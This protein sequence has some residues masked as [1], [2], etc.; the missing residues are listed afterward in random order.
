[1]SPFCG[2]LVL[3]WRL[4]RAT[5]IETGLF[6][7]QADYLSGFRRG[8]QVNPGKTTTTMPTAKTRP[9]PPITRA[10]TNDGWIPNDPLPFVLYRD[11]VDLTGSPDPER[12]IGEIPTAGRN[13]LCRDS[14]AEH[15]K[16]LVSIRTVPRPEI[17]P[18]FGPQGPLIM[19]WRL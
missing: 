7:I 14:K 19:L 6:E 8:R 15:T 3:L 11:A 1:M 9:A 10:F 18:V 2:Y 5:T 17:D 16:A 13:V 12:I 4:R